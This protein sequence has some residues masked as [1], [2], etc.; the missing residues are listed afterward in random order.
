MDQVMLDG[1]RQN[2]G[3]AS[4]QEKRRIEQDDDVA[5]F[6]TVPDKRPLRT[7]GKRGC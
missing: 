6:W 2:T 3:A 7:E 5:P 1:Q 4:G